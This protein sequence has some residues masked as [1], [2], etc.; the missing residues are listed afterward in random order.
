MK[1]AYKGLMLVWILAWASTASAQIEIQKMSDQVYALVGDMDQRSPENLGNNSTHGVV[2]LKDGVLLIDSGGSYLGAEALD[3]AIKTITNKP[4]K[5]VI[6]SG[7]QDH[8]WLGNGYFK[9][10]GAQIYSSERALQDQ[11]SGCGQMLA[12]MENFIGKDKMQGTACVYADQ[13]FS[14]KV[15]LV[16][17]G[18]KFELHHVGPG[19]TKGD[20]FTWMPSEKTVFAGDIV[21]NDRALGIQYTKDVKGWI[22]TFEALAEFNPQWVVP[23]HGKAGN[24]AK[25][26]KD[27][28]DYLV[29][30]RDEVSRILDEGGSMTDAGN[31]D[32]SRF[33]YLYQLDTIGA[34]NALG[35]FETL[36]FEF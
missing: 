32:Q 34:K 20:F 13:T 36:E 35:I 19:H 30:L 25:A 23:G 5:W 26:R 11:K 31:I 12:M 9:Q 27:T 18:E 15:S 14:D 4:V 1:T 17:S 3:K 16:L 29:F 21:F 2:V 7:S 33:D 6:N 24:L 22:S 10:K 8:R 28:Y